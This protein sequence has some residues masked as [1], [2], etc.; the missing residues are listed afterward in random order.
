MNID[1]DPYFSSGG[2]LF[3]TLRGLARGLW[4]HRGTTECTALRKAIVETTSRLLM[5]LTSGWSFFATLSPEVI[6][7]HV[8]R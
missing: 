7:R 8:P 5:G 1:L 4:R 2:D 6:R 3:R